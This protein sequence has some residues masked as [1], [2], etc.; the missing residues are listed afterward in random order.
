[1]QKE[2]A[3]GIKSRKSIHSV[4]KSNRMEGG[5]SLSYVSGMDPNFTGA[6]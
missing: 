3:I 6:G 5:I 2:K 1:M 4:A